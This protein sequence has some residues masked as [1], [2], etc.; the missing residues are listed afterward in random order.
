MKAT[1]NKTLLMLLVPFVFQLHSYAQSENARL[2]PYELN[3]TST[4]KPDQITDILGTNPPT[5]ANRYTKDGL[6]LSEGLDS[7]S[8]FT[9]DEIPFDSENGIEVE[10]QYAMYDGA[11]YNGNYGDGLA[12]FIYDGAKATSIGS[13]GAGLGYVY[14]NTAPDN[15]WFALPGMDGGF[16]AI[17]LDLYGGFKQRS[18]NPYEMREGISFDE[19]S[20]N[21][22]GFNHL[23]IRAAGMVGNLQKGYPVLFST[24]L[25]DANQQSNTSDYTRAVLDY[26]SGAYLLSSEFLNPPISMMPQRANGA[27]EAIQYNTI[28]LIL[29]P[30]EDGTSTYITVKAANQTTSTSVVENLVYPTRFNTTFTDDTVYDFVNS[31][32]ET[33]KIGFS[34]STGGATATQAIKYVKVS[35]PYDP[36]TLPEYKELCMGG[37]INHT[38]LNP[39]ENDI[40]YNGKI[41]NPTAGND[42]VHIDFTSFRFEDEKGFAL[43]QNNPYL[44]ENNDGI[45]QYNPT[46]QLV[47]FTLKN[48]QD[49]NVEYKVYYSA[50]GNDQNG[51]PFHNE[52]Y[53]SA[54][55]P[56]TIKSYNCSV[57][58]NPSLRTKQAKN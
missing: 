43:D 53:R 9:L 16:L 55:T 2:F 31:T 37:T 23:T 4:T 57:P 10:F 41:A 21:N 14:R 46:T 36:I 30:N 32:P 19:G 20:W 5:G 47:T 26:Q 12:F 28:T 54:P 22:Q 17:A 1:S 38:T 25:D 42:A 11:K 29:V 51:G 50:Y 58:V 15:A 24:Q 44:Y 49:I 18:V 56:I 35:L 27:S 6:V 8:A 13:Y 39:F 45:W 33:F 3:F 40:F 52:Y 48:T 34:A 7:S